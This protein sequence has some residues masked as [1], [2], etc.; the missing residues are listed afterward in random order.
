MGIRNSKPTVTTTQVQTITVD[1]AVNC[2]GL[3]AFQ[4]KVLFATG[5]CFMADSV[6]VMLLSILTR[7]LQR[8][9]DFP[10]EISSR[11]TSC[12]FAGATVGTL[13]LG[14]LGDR[15]GR[16]PVLCWANLIILCFGLGTA[17]T[18]NYYQL[19][20]IIFF[21]GFGW[22]VCLLWSSLLCLMIFAFRYGP[23]SPQ[24]Y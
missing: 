8:E 18:Q 3:G 13:I 15:I 23:Y 5:T 7:K 9:W 1:S 20:P 19:F 14:P 2:I 4:H 21:V 22:V 11:I 12:L 17:F 6:Q 10:E 16:K 24:L